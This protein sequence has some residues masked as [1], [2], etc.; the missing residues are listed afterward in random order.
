MAFF[1]HCLGE[2]PLCKV[3]RYTVGFFFIGLLNKILL[4]YLKKVFK[5]HSDDVI[6]RKSLSL[7]SLKFAPSSSPLLAF[8]ENM[9]DV[10]IFRKCSSLQ[11][12]DWRSI[13][14]AICGPN[15]ICGLKTSADP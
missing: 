15:F 2:P 10:G 3:A 8:V 13:F 5:D 14:F 1:S 4:F 6:I 9:L 12:C 11:I 7:L